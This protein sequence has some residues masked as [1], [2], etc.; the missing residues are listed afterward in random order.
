MTGVA[1]NVYKNTTAFVMFVAIGQSNLLPSDVTIHYIVNNISCDINTS[2]YI[3]H[4]HTFVY[5]VD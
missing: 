1:G 4:Y 5:T 3:L 2:V